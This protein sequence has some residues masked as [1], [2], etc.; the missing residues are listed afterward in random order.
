I[1]GTSTSPARNTSFG[2]SPYLGRQFNDQ[3][4][5]GVRL[6]YQGRFYKA[7]G[8]VLSTLIDTIDF[9][10]VNHQGGLS[11]F[12][13]WTFNP[14]NKVQ[15]FVEP[16]LG[17]T[18]QVAELAN[19]GIPFDREITQFGSLNASLGATYSLSQRW[20]L[21]VRSGS[22]SLLVGQWRL[23]NSSKRNNFTLF[24]TSLSLSS[25]RFGA[26]LLF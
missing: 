11:I 3:T 8:V 21:L 5:L 1:L 15:V 17:Y 13:R 10:R 25:I 22:A 23:D 7:E 26:E 16:S 12:L 2:A 24:N 4:L 14:Q 6:E 20:R 18:A 19:D 9:T